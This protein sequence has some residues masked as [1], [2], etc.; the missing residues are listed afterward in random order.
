MNC[1]GK[2][3]RGTIDTSQTVALHTG[4]SSFRSAH[5]CK[6]CGMLHWEDGTPCINRQGNKTFRRSDGRIVVV[7]RE[8]EDD[9]TAYC[10]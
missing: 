6:I 8:G 1:S 10:G 9:I 5:P 3:C 7:N 4:C 2:E